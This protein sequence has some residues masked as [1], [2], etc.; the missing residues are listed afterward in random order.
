MK[1]VELQQAQQQTA[2]P[3]AGFAT[4]G[5]AMRIAMTAH[6]IVAPALGIRDPNRQP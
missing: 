6:G 5:L 1:S 2:V 4:R 3:G